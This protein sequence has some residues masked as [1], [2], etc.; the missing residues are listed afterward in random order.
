MVL[1]LF[2]DK[3]KRALA[4]CENTRRMKF[5]EVDKAKNF[6]IQGF[7]KDLIEVDTHLIKTWLRQIRY[8]NPFLEAFAKTIATE[9]VSY[10][11]YKSY[12]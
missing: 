4:D 8:L 5:V 10:S 6:A 12:N 9:T 7:C 3:Y 2:Q 1:V 11:Y